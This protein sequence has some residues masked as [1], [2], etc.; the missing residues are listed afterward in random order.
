MKVHTGLGA[1]QAFIGLGALA[2]GFMLVKDPSGR[3]LGL[4]I[5]F[6]EG[7]PFADFFIPGI[8]LLLVNGA[9]SMMGAGYSFT[10]RRYAPELAMAL[11]LILVAWI[12]IQVIVIRSF[13]WIQVLYFMLGAAEF[14]MGLYIRRRQF[15]AAYKNNRPNELRMTSSLEILMSRH[16][17][18]AWRALLFQ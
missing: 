17:A 1:L 13:H 4:P 18:P 10:K 5:S 15:K 12:V 16:F 14:E 8:F 7:S 3:A 6:L 11:G 2:G 9:G